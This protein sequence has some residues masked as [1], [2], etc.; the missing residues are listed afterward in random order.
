MSS[1]HVLLWPLFLP[2]SPFHLVHVRWCCAKSACKGDAQEKKKEKHLLSCFSTTSSKRP[3]SLLLLLCVNECLWEV[4]LH[5]SKASTIIYCGE[6]NWFIPSLVLI[7]PKLVSPTFDWEK[8]MSGRIREKL[9]GRLMVQEDQSIIHKWSVANA[10]FVTERVVRLGHN[11]S[12]D[13]MF[14]V[15][16]MSAVCVCVIYHPET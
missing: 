1:L 10:L 8:P 11:V 14:E 13:A 2:P 9:R 7:K 5:Q 6:W 15:C 16:G 3:E 4:K 12:H